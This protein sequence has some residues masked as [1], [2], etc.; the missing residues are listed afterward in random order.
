[1]DCVAGFKDQEGLKAL[2]KHGVG[3]WGT[4]RLGR[5]VFGGD[6]VPPGLREVLAALQGHRSHRPDAERGHDTSFQALVPSSG[7]TRACPCIH[8]ALKSRRTS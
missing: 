1:M 5:A 8:T 6:T 7:S 3:R 2:E 4:L